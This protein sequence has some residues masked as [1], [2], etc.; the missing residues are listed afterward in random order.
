MGDGME[1]KQ[2]TVQL[3]YELEIIYLSISKES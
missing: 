3:K 1:G 2:P